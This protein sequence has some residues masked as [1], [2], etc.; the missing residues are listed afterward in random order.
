MIVQFYD[1]KVD[2]P[3]TLV[4]KFTKDFEGLPGNGHNESVMQLRSAIYE[5][6]DLVEEDPELLDEKEYM[7][8]FVR[9]LAM[10]QALANH[11]ILYDA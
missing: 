6:L 4:T 1:M 7:L 9:A 5:V 11:G 3:D 2:V 8:D 10:Q